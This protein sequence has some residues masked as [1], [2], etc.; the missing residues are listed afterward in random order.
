MTEI[1][2]KK[3]LCKIFKLLSIIALII[4]L[5]EI[6]IFLCKEEIFSEKKMEN[7]YT[8]IVNDYQWVNKIQ[9]RSKIFL[10]GSSSV[11]YSL[12]C[13]QLN[14]L[15]NDTLSFINLARPAGDPIE[16][17]FL[18]KKFD[19]TGVKTVYYGLDPMIF[20]KFYYRLKRSHLYLDM[21]LLQAIRLS[22]DL[23]QPIFR[24]R[25]SAFYQYLVPTKRINNNNTQLIPADFGSE[26]LLRKPRN[27][28]FPVN[29][30]FQIDIYGWSQ[31]EFSYLMKIADFCKKKNIEFST[32]VPP[33]RSDFSKIYK[34]E[35]NLI[36]KEFVNN[37]IN[38]NF[39]SPIFGKFD[40]LD[41]FGDYNLYAEPY[42]LNPQGQRVYT[43]IF[44]QMTLKKKMIFSSNYSWFLKN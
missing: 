26:K 3:F 18:L 43:G 20:S 1:D 14:K 15:S 42:H 31:L 19:L 2:M 12:S 44:Y 40:Q 28:N 37:L 32:F 10:A 11:K 17:Y 36:H 8:D 29:L 13:T 38:V 22:I 27:F 35:C 6:T 7:N 4:F 39:R 16:M 34:L 25:Y 30:W 9:S 23:E 41:S 24:R 5:L 21:T 33:K